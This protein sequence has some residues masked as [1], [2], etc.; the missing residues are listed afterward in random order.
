MSLEDEF[1]I[2]ILKTKIVKLASGYKTFSYPLIKTAALKYTLPTITA[3]LK[4]F[5]IIFS[6]NIPAFKQSFNTR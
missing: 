1:R 3:C 4:K 6:L 2:K 5:L